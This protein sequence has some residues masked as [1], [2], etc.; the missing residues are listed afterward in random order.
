MFK[1]FLPNPFSWSRTSDSSHVGRQL[2]HYAIVHVRTIAQ[3]RVFNL[4]L[5][6]ILRHLFA[7]WCCYLTHQTIYYHIYKTAV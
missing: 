3:E 4:F 1:L 6:R 7:V 5:V 2:L